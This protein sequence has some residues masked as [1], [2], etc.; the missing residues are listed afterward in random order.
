MV[1]LYKYKTLYFLVPTVF[2]IVRI[3]VNNTMSVELMDGH[4]LSNI[5][6][7]IQHIDEL[8]VHALFSEDKYLEEV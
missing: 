4:L 1:R 7:N 5:L 3:L 2:P 8:L 6:K